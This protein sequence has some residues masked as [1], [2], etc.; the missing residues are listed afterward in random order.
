MSREREIASTYTHLSSPGLP[1]SL[2][3]RRARDSWP[4]RSLGVDGTG[5]SSTPRPLGSA[6]LSLEYWITRCTG[7]DTAVFYVL[8]CNPSSSSSWRR[9]G[10][11]T[12]NLDCCATLGA[13]S[14]LF[15][16]RGG[17]GSWLFAGTTNGEI[18][19]RYDPHID[20]AVD[21]RLRP[22]AAHPIAFRRMIALVGRQH[23]P[24]PA[25]AE[26]AQGIPGHPAPVRAVLDPILALILA[27]VADGSIRG[28]FSGQSGSEGITPAGAARIPP[29]FAY[30]P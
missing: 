26:L 18:P 16:E 22:L 14:H 8:G 4:R 3:L 12:P 6:P 21:I 17:Y 19:C 20:Q 15:T 11:I 25:G 29:G 9:P 10:P 2:K 13:R 24:G 7:D 23:V 1:P 28:G 27:M 30:R 5:R